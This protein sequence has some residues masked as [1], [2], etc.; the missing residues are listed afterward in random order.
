MSDRHLHDE[1]GMVYACPN[2]DNAPVYRRVDR[3]YNNRGFAPDAPFVCYDCSTG[4][5]EPVER[6]EHISSG[7]PGPRS[8]AA[9]RIL[10]A[11]PT[12]L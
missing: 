7:S 6:E 4:F 3:E 12:T 2:C 10:N 1:E 8:D 5:N 11:D 9:K